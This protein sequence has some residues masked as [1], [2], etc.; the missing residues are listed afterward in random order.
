MHPIPQSKDDSGV[1]DRRGSRTWGEGEF[2]DDHNF[3]NAA[4]NGQDEEQLHKDQGNTRMPTAASRTELPTNGASLQDEDVD[5]E[6]MTPD[7]LVKEVMGLRTRLNFRYR[8]SN[9]HKDMI[10]ELRGEVSRL[11]SKNNGLTGEVKGLAGENEGL[12]SENE[13]LRGENKELKTE[14]AKFKSE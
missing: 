6:N 8:V 10:M 3:D 14:L 13:G 7:Q 11:K 2:D 1:G 4:E 5:I 12:R 9:K